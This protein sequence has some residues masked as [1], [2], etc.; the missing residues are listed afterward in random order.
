[1]SDLGFS[2]RQEHKTTTRLL[3]TQSNLKSVR[4]NF[5]SIFRLVRVETWYKALNG[6]MGGIGLAKIIIW[7][8]VISQRKKNDTQEI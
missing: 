7:N 2:L 1:M 6:I 4:L 8:I 5:R 3:T